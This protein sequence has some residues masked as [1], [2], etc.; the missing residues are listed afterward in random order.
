MTFERGKAEGT[1]FGSCLVLLRRVVEAF[2]DDF[3]AD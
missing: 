1:H 2:T 3:L